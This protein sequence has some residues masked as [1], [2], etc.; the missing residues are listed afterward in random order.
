MGK[1]HHDRHIP[2]KLQL[3]VHIPIE[4]VNVTNGKCVPV[5]GCGTNFMV[6]MCSITHNPQIRD[7]PHMFRLE[8]F[9]LSESGDNIDVRGNNLRLD[10]FIFVC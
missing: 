4:D 8:I 6:N 3:Y 5:G 2:I 10:P 9:A 7:S 1:M